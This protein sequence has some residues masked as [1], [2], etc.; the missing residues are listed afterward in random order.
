MIEGVDDVRFDNGVFSVAENLA[1]FVRYYRAALEVI[2]IIGL[3]VI[4]VKFFWT[5]VYKMIDYRY[6]LYLLCGG[7]LSGI[8]GVLAYFVISNSLF[9]FSVMQLP[10]R[11]LLVMIAAGVW[12]VFVL[13]N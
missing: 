9:P 3:A 12:A 7:L 11:Y 13:E 2:F 6:Y 10:I 5:R 8:M 1:I 4:L